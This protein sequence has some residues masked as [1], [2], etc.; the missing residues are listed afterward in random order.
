ML[1]T[2]P[3]FARFALPELHNTDALDIHCVPGGATLGSVRWRIAI[4]EGA[5]VALC[6][7]PI[8][9]AESLQRG[10][11]DRHRDQKA[12]SARLA[13]NF[14]ESR[15]SVVNAASVRWNSQ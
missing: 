13:R 14:D 7:S 2:P 3:P 1:R 9:L 6:R 11:V 5:N 10:T 12:R 15:G 8:C 4:V